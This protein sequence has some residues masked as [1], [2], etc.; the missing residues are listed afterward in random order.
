MW[1]AS[2]FATLTYSDEHLP[3]PP[4]LSKRDHQLF[5]KRLRR[6]L[7]P[8]RISFFLCGEYGEQGGRPHYH[9]ILFGYW[10]KDAVA[11][12]KNKAGDQLYT[13]AQLERVW[14]KGFTSFGAVT[15]ES[16]LYVAGYVTKKETH[17]AGESSY[18]WL[19]PQTGELVPVEPEYGRMSRRPAIGKKWVE[20]YGNSDAFRHDSVVSGGRQ[21]PVPRY[22]GKL[23]AR[24]DPDKLAVIARNR[25]L[26]REARGR[27]DETKARRLAREKVE[28]ARV[29][30]RKKEL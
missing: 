10:P 21:H 9:A 2:C 25:Y 4:S 14:G 13:S 28:L 15:F 22:Y 23:L 29:N 12:K 7:A 18:T 1:P 30:L 5:L 16:A 6:E 27:K 24:T 11:W 17:Y 3:H 26:R 19:D 20:R 8:Q